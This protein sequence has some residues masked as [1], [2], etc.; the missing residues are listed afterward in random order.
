MIK[1]VALKNQFYYYYYFFKHKG[2]DIV[3]SVASP[4]LSCR[5]HGRSGSHQD[6]QESQ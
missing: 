4:K 1:G 5:R 2:N 3:V 6:N